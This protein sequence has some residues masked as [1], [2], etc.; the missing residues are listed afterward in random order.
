MGKKKKLAPPR[1]LVERELRT[2]TPLRAPVHLKRKGAALVEKIEEGLSVRHRIRTMSA[3]DASVGKEALADPYGEPAI[4]KKMRMA[5]PPLRRSANPYCENA[6]GERIHQS[7]LP[8]FMWEARLAEA[9]TSSQLLETIRTRWLPIVWSHFAHAG[10]PFGHLV[11]VQDCQTGN[12]LPERARAYPKP[13]LLC[14]AWRLPAAFRS[15]EAS[16]E[17]VAGNL[18][19]IAC[20]LAE[21]LDDRAPRLRQRFADD[22]DAVKLLD[23]T[24]LAAAGAG[25]FATLQLL[26]PWSEHPRGKPVLHAA[27]D[28]AR[29]DTEGLSGLDREKHTLAN[30]LRTAFDAGEIRSAGD[31]ARIVRREWGLEEDDNN[32]YAIVRE[33]EWYW[34]IRPVQG[35]PGRRRKAPSLG[36]TLPKRQTV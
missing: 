1:Q 14:P 8:E 15:E 27:R 31:Y 26:S 6:A 22:P 17:G 30:V 36:N 3:A 28:C 21:V 16:P 32:A 19:F 24:T 23:A 7:H 4:S 5:P 9:A 25:M 11:F 12:W 35:L 20:A 29:R 10:L 33:L 34:L 13:H 18:L 2:H